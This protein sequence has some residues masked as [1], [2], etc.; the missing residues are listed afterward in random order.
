MPNQIVQCQCFDVDTRVRFWELCLE[1]DESSAWLERV[2]VGQ[3]EIFAVRSGSSAVCAVALGSER[4]VFAGCPLAIHGPI[5]GR[6]SVGTGLGLVLVE[7][8]FRLGGLGRG[9]W[10]LVGVS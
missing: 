10:L 5:E 3:L 9:W 4:I 6:L 8:G 1:P 7:G 2:K